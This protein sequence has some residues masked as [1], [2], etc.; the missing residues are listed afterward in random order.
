MKDDQFLDALQKGNLIDE[1]VATK[2]KRE[3]L[4]SGR[5]AEEIIYERRLIDDV[6][7]AN[8]KSQLYGVPYQKIDFDN[9]D[10]K[11]LELI[12]EETVRTYAVTPISRAENLFVIGMLHPDDQKAQDALKFIARRGHFNLGIYLISYTDW[13]GIL[14][15]YSPY[16]SVLEAAVRS[17]N[18]KSNDGGR[19]V[20]SLEERNQ[21]S[22]EEAPIIRI[23]ADTLKEA[24]EG[25]A[26]DVHV[27]PQEN[28]LRIRFRIDGE[29]HE[30]ASLPLEIAQA[31]VS[32]IK[33]ISNLKIDETRIPQDGRFRSRI[34]NR[35]IDF[36]VATFPTP[37]GEKVAIRILDSTVGLKTF[38]QLG[39]VG[40]N[41][42][43]IKK[44]LAKPFGMIIVSGPTGS[45]KSTTLYSLLQTLN[46]EN[47]NI[48][49]LEDPVEYF[50]SGLNQSQVRPEIGYDFAS[51]LRQILRQ[52]PDVIMVGEIRDNET[53]GLAIHAALTGHIVLSTLHTNNAAGVIPRL[54]D[55][56]VEPFLLPAALNLMV[57]QRLVPLL[58]ENCKAP[59]EAP[60]AIQKEIKHALE[61]LPSEIAGQYKEPY[62]IYRAV[63]C[64]KCNQKGFSGRIAL[65][66]VFEMSH[67]V[68]AIIISDPT[69][70]KLLAETRK[71]NM[72]TLRQDGVLKALAGKI[73]I[74]GVFRETSDD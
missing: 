49:S 10:D 21:A 73:S 13:Q 46:N 12:P 16:K 52:D 38:D 64:N 15:K 30:I 14:R 22:L 25:H 68:E 58:C 20:V 47:V 29:L 59:L 48:V 9:F 35:E 7:L 28:Y 11:L 51:G 63:G 19:G 70:E 65:F 74:E 42:E 26:S 36:R 3:V 53:A 57:A 18:V 34:L 69:A 55:M 43:I 60:P 67:A 17:L 54:I 40:R 62:K 31:V 32:R 66:E 72:I 56:K 41:L 24:V 50:I 71:Q 6:V 8:F 1:T 45:G 37:L 27:E 4:L 33:V 39:L 23:V 2:L 44:G 5:L 61:N